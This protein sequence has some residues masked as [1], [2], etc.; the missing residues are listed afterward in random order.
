MKYNVIEFICYT[1]SV[2]SS[3]VMLNKVA[4]RVDFLP[5][6]ALSGVHHLRGCT[7]CIPFVCVHT[8]N[9]YVMIDDRE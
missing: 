1:N 6:R 9:K 5:L 2:Y 4:I 7:L 8:I 3:D